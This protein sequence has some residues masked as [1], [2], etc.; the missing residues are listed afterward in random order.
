[1]HELL[2]IVRSCAS[3]KGMKMYEGKLKIKS[4][5]TEVGTIHPSLRSKLVETMPVLGSVLERQRM[6]A[7]VPD[8]MQVA[9]FW[10][11]DTAHSSVSKAQLA[12]ENPAVQTQM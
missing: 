6:V 7:E 8:S 2:D 3:Q 9:P 12:S 5:P 1:M 10:H 4:P 11:S